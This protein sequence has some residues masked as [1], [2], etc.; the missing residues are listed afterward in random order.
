MSLP[1]F[2]SHLHLF[3]NIT[4]EDKRKVEVPVYSVATRKVNPLTFL[5]SLVAT[6]PNF[7]GSLYAPFS[8]TSSVFIK[9]D[10]MEY[11]I[12]KVVLILLKSPEVL[13]TSSS[14]P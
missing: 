6:L 13:D 7:R 2:T 10:R 12:L 11:I 1:K 3:K 14:H 8:D 9:I 5:P 4:K